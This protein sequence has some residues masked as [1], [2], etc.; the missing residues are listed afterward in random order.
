MAATVYNTAAP[1]AQPVVETVQPVQ[2]FEIIS[3]SVREIEVIDPEFVVGMDD[4][5]FSLDLFDA[6]AET[7]QNTVVFE[8]SEETKDIKVNEAVQFYPVTELGEEGIIKYTLEEE[9]EETRKKDNYIR[10]EFNYQSFFRSFS[11][12]EYIDE[13]KIEANYKDGILHIDIAKK[14]GGKRKTTKKIAIK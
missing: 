6:K 8:L 2:E 3:N 9:I 7:T 12:P 1:V 4:F 11:L 13:S 10:K 5:N 14:E